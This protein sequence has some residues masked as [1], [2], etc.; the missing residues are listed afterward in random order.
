M[1]L[2]VLSRYL[3]AT[4][5][6]RLAGRRLQPRGLVS[7]RLAG[8]HASPLRGFAVEFAGHR[9]YVW[10]DDPK[11]IDWRLYYTRDKYFVKQYQ[12]ETNLV[13]H[14]AIDVSASMGYGG[15]VQ[16]K[17]LYAARLAASLAYAAIERRDQVSLTTLGDE[18]LTFVPPSRGA[19]QLARISDELDRAELAG[20]TDLAAS[21]R[22]LCG[23]IGRREIVL[24]FSD[25]F[26][27]LEQLD[28]VL[29]RM[30]FQRL[31]VVLFQVLHHDEIEF[32]FTGTTKFV[33]LEELAELVAESHE[34]RGAYLEA[35]ARRQARL[36][37]ICG[38]NQVDLALIDTSR[39]PAEALVGYLNSRSR[40]GRAARTTSTR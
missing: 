19:A 18:R 33:G 10:G 15:G 8:P 24:V 9:E 40:S 35:F 37:E 34:L 25:L 21:L 30:R 3:D 36:A 11:H 5:L 2:G 22:Q 39:N 26:T 14:L 23:R 7:G 4:V 17:F 27:D 6:S 31:D 16:Q 32:D 20:K 1:A 38:R 28:E 13:C 29:H 12:A